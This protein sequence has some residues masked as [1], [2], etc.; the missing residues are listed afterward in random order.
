MYIYI[1]IYQRAPG[2]T[3]QLRVP[4]RVHEGFELMEGEAA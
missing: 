1:Y 4:Q 2:V 3:G